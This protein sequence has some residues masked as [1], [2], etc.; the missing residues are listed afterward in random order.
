MTGHLYLIPNSLG[1]ADPETYL[2]LQVQQLI[3]GL[4]YFVVEKTRNAR[5]FLKTVDK[6]I[7]IDGL[8]FYELNKHTEPGEVAAFLKPVLAGHDMGVISEAGMPGV[9]DPGAVLVRQAHLQNIPVIPL[10]GPS[11][12]F[13]ALMASGLNGQSFRFVGY[14][15][16]QRGERISAVKRL[17]RIVDETRETQIFI[18]T[19][20]R[21]N[22]LLGDICAACR[23]QTMLTIA[24]DITMETEMI[25][26]V[27]VGVWKK[28]K[29]DLHKRPAVFLLGKS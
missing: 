10:S 1:N 7:V 12:I 14:L 28:K 19:P 23:D 22:V 6:E 11:S 2:P 20:Y 15:P 17:E 4:K 13:M 24:A 5:R 9:A 25:K 21:N 3:T 16:V 26:T 18:E 8:T 29:P 27:A